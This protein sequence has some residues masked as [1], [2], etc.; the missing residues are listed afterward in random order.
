MPIMTAFYREHPHI[1]P[2]RDPRGSNERFMIYQMR[3]VLLLDERVRDIEERYT[4]QRQAQRRFLAAA[5]FVSPALLMQHAL[6]EVAGTGVGR[7]AHFDA[8]LDAFFSEWRAFFIPRIYNRVPVV[9]H[10][11]TPRFSYVEEQMSH[12]IA[13]SVPD[14]LIIGA[15]TLLLGLSARRTRRVP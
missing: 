13:Q 10:T 7:R 12:V 11:A 5:R 8:Q 1:A 14:M 15:A 4:R 6:E 3:A 2:A 9:E